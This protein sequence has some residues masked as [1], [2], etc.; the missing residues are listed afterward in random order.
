MR[1]VTVFFS[2]YLFFPAAYDLTNRN[3]Y[4]NCDPIFNMKPAENQTCGVDIRK[5]ASCSVSNSFGLSSQKPCIFVKFDTE[6]GWSPE[7]YNINELP[8]EMPQSLRSQIESNVRAN[9]RNNVSLSL[10]QF[11][12]QNRGSHLPENIFSGNFVALMRRSERRRQASSWT[13]QYLASKW[14][15]R[16]L[17]RPFV[18]QKREVMYGSAR[19]HSIP[20]YRNKYDLLHVSN[21][22]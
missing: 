13:D 5:F 21:I 11:F 10:K 20:E 16:N 18:V 4:P 6:P 15:S 9:P 12:H 8:D 17:F 7:Y 14:I 2:I 1:G 22:F 19:G 3:V